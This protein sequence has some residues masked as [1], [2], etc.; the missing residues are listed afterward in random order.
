MV[1][2]RN[3]LEGRRRWLL[4]GFAVVS[5]LMVPLLGGRGRFGRTWIDEAFCEADCLIVVIWVAGCK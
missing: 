2:H 3:G 5:A 4:G 1:R